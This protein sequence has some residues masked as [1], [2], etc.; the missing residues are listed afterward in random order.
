L[1][2]NVAL[3]TIAPLVAEI[4]ADPV[5]TA[6]ASP[7]VP[8]AFETVATVALSAFQVVVLVRF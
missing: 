1:T 3:P 5:P 4:E 8:A 6:V 2:V 7:I